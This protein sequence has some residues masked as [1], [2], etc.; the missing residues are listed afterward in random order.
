METQRETN[1][2]ARWSH[3]ERTVATL[4]RRVQKRWNRG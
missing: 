2:I 1:G 4:K 3:E